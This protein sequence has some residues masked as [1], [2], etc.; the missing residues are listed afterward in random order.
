MREES[1]GWESQGASQKKAEA[2]LARV[3]GARSDPGAPRTL[4]EERERAQAEREA[5]QAATEQEAR[6][7]RTF[8]EVFT[9][10]YLPWS[11]ANKRNARSWQREEALHRLWLAPVFGDMAMRDVAP[12]H[13]EKVK[14]RMLKAGRSPRSVQYAVA[15]VRQVFNFATR[16]SLYAGDNPATKVKA[17][18]IDNRRFRFL[19]TDEASRLLVELKHRSRDVH[20]M[21]LLSINT[22]MRA[23]EAFS[24]TW[25][26]VDERAGI[27]TLRDTKSGK[28][29]QAFFTKAVREMFAD[30]HR[31]KPTDLVFPARGG[32]KIV[33]ISNAFDR[34]VKALGLNDGIEDRRMKVTFHTC[35]HTFGSWLVQRGVDLYRV[36]EL[37][38]HA[39][40][41]MTSR[42]AHLAPETLRAAVSVLDQ[43]E[44]A[45]KKA[46]RPTW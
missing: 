10:H 11:Q 45:P 4:A 33:Q 23:G 38:G 26:D 13:L 31:G 15:T 20:D 14:Q 3:K 9:A 21:A 41:A 24:L 27:I 28:T 25:G 5:K 6:D 36:K 1:I 42:Y 46:T 44:R 18:K 35:R 43:G 29:R 19:T 16:N 8:S 32:G 17:P 30:R 40:F 34:S 39:D 2:A 37:M 7:N 22:G 12:I